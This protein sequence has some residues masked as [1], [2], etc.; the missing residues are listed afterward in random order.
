[1]RGGP[2][3]LTGSGVRPQAMTEHSQEVISGGRAHR[4]CCPKGQG[5][6]EVTSFKVRHSQEVLLVGVRHHLGKGKGERGVGKSPHTR[7]SR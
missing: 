4:K 2:K 6:Q 3:T 7:C 5:T 1:M